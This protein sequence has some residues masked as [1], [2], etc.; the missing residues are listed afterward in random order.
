MGNANIAII[1]L[2]KAGEFFLEQL[3]KR[4]DLGLNIVCAVEP[5]DN[6]GRQRAEESGIALV[7]IDDVVSFGDDVD[8]IFNLTGN[9][10]LQVDLLAKLAAASN[11][12]TEVVSDKV[13]KVIWSILSENHIPAMA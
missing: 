8:F 9:P 4:I 12:H 2:G 1:G 11:D 5:A 7:S 10:Q 6:S 13:L 3:I